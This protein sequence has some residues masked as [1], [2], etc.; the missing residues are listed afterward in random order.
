M[1]VLIF[2][3]FKGILTFQISLSTDNYM[4]ENE[5]KY[6]CNMQIGRF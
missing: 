1:K 4:M 6:G 5:D 2:N 3:I